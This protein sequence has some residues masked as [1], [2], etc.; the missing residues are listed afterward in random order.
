[1]KRYAGLLKYFK[2][3]KRSIA[4]YMLFTILSIVFGIVSISMLIPFLD[5]LFNPGQRVNDL[6]PLHFDAGSILKTLSYY[7][8]QVINEQGVITALA[9][10]CAIIITSIFLKNLFL[11]LSYYVLSPMRNNVMTRLRNDLYN[12]IL[13]LPIGYFTEQRKGDLISRMTNDTWELEGTVVNTMEGFIKEPLTIIVILSTL[14]FLSPQ[15]SVFLLI[16]LPVTGFVIGRVSRSLKKQSNAAAIKSGEGLSI[17]DETL[18]GLRVIKAFNAEHILRSKFLS[19]ND[20]LFRVK[21]KMNYRR[22]L[23]SPMSEFLGVLVLCGI[24]WFGG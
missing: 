24:L 23:A 11:Y 5:V 4:L 3:F 16:F 21:N 10:I 18:T 12:K 6:P 15:L 9:Y 1:M 13:S 17:L 19:T 8:S 7:L 2:P 22:D 20:A 14:I